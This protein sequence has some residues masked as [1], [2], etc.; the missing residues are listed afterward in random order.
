MPRTPKRGRRPGRGA[1]SIIAV[2]LLGSALL[3]VGMQ[4]SVAIAREASPAELAQSLPGPDPLVEPQTCESDPDL[5]P[6]LEAMETREE[7]LRVREE[8]MTMRMRALQ[9]ADAR[10]SEKLTELKASEQALR[11]TIALADEAAESDLT[12]LTTVYENMKPKDAAALFETMDP[13]FAAG[14]LGR[15]RPDAAAG[16]MTGLT[17]QTA[18]MVSVVLAGRN[19]DVPKE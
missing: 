19:A 6:L 16:I 3:R 17:P 13:E 15:M 8:R 5:L 18:Y 12:R 11:A 9:V 4:A 10:I 7:R 2:L 14:F 1:L